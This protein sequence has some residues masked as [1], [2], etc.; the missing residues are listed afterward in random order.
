MGG[1]PSAEGARRDAPRGRRWGL[2]APFCG[3]AA[4]PGSQPRGA[5][6]SAEKRLQRPQPRL[7][8]AQICRVNTHRGSSAHPLVLIQH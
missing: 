2:G 3:P 5:M 1:A 7:R 6:A 8:E 4:A